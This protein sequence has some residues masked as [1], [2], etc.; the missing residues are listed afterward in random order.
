[1]KFNSTT[2]RLIYLWAFVESGLGGLMHLF[3]IPITGFV[4]GGF[5]II[6]NIL[7][8]K[9]SDKNYKILLS[10]IGL[11]LLIKFTLSPQSPA[12]A[13]VAVAFQGILSIVLFKIFSV[14]RIS[15]LIYSCIVMFEN[16]IQKPLLAYIVGGSKLSN[17]IV[18]LTNNFFHNMEYA[19]KF[20]I[21]FISLYF[22]IYFLWGL[23]ISIWAV[24]FIKKL[25]GY[26]LPNDFFENK[27]Y[28]QTIELENKKSNFYFT[29][30]TIVFFIILFL[31]Y[32]K[33][34]NL[35]YIFKTIALFIFI[36]ILLPYII[37]KLLTKYQIK[38]SS[39][40]AAIISTFPKLK[41]NCFQS[42]NSTINLKGLHR[43]KEF[44]FLCIYS[45]VY[46]I[47]DES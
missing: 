21:G 19:Q 8:A 18:D 12:G 15:I 6:I 26:K 28:N 45:N 10:G 11:V 40:L 42:Y 37:R 23:L 16:A 33:Y 22:L 47:E 38:Y 14:N 44:V 1:M 13:Y 39:S 31:L 20:L 17:G 43:W 5:S 34:E 3:H 2:L 35:G 30:F 32:L 25:E 46:Y 41:Y 4:I 9:S 36:G 27:S 29:V 7:L 24:D